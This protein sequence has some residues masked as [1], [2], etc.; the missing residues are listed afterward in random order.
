M[1]RVAA[2]GKMILLGEYAV[3]DG[4]P[5]LVCAVDK[6]AYVTMEP[7]GG[8]EFI[9]NAPSLGLQDLPF[10][11]T[12]KHHVRFDPSLSP[13]MLKRLDLFSKIFEYT[14]AQIAPSFDQGWHITINTDDFYSHALHTKFGFGSSA[15]LCVA[16]VT[17]MGQAFNR[18]LSKAALFRL[19][20][21]AHHYAQGKIGSG[22]DIA[23]S[24]FG[25][26]LIYQRIFEHDPPEKIPEK[27]DACSGLHFTP[28]FTGH[29]ASTRKLVK[30]V[31]QLQEQFPQIYAEIM[32][33]LKQISRQGSLHFK[34]QNTEAFLEDVRSFYDALKELGD[35]SAMPI[36][37]ETHQ[38]IFDLAQQEQVAYKPSGAGSGDIGILFSEDAQRLKKAEEKVRAAGY[39]PLQI[40]VAR[41]GVH[42]L[43]RQN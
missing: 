38:R 4:A 7:L 33:R 40:Q 26:Y 18:P 3:L 36:I 6:W 41:Q 35:R 24:F 27:I 28:V 10:V 43:E 20:L 25:G 30:G 15:A 42:A 9:F 19:A 23:A 17:A 13:S 21:Q 11:I 31:K 8:M 32:D 5:A 12:P 29:S 39:L 16:L 2:P 34:G 22:I 37:S 14:W 1:I